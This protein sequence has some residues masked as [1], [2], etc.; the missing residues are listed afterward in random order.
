MRRLAPKSWWT[1]P[2]SFMASELL[3]I[4]GHEVT[5]SN[6]HKVLFPQSG[7]TKLDLVNYYLA[8]SE[9]ALPTARGTG[10]QAWLALPGERVFAWAPR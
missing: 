3:V 8:V 5:I 2:P 9:G 10:R 7:Y 1:I 6:P 4:D